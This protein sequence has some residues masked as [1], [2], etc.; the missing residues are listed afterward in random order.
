MNSEVYLLVERIGKKIGVNDLGHG[1]ALGI[2]D[3]SGLLRVTKLINF[4]VTSD[5]VL[6]RLPRV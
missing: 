1:K 4:R 5:N 6:E 2:Y 3:D